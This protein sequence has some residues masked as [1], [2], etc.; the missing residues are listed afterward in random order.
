MK[1]EFWD[2]TLNGIDEKYTDSAAE[3]LTKE[4][5]IE[6]GRAR[7]IKPVKQ[8]RSGLAA[9]IGVCATAAAALAVVVGIKAFNAPKNP[10]APSD[11]ISM[12]LADYTADYTLYEKY[13]E[14]VWKNTDEQSEKPYLVI[15]HENVFGSLDGEV[16]FCEAGEECAMTYL[17][18]DARV[19]F[20]RDADGTLNRYDCADALST[21]NG[22]ATYEYADEAESGSSVG[23]VYYKLLCERREGLS[24]KLST[25]ELD[26]D[27][28]HWTRA[29]TDKAQIRV[30]SENNAEISLSAQFTNDEGGA[31]YLKLNL[32]G[33]GWDFDNVCE[34]DILNDKT[35]LESFG[36]SLNGEFDYG[37]YESVF[38]G[39]WENAD[40]GSEMELSYSKTD[41]PWENVSSVGYLDGFW[42][43]WGMSGGAGEFLYIS[44]EEPDVMYSAELNGYGTPI[45][46]YA[47][48]PYNIYYRKEIIPAESAVN[49]CTISGAQGSGEYNSRSL[50]GYKAVNDYLESVEGF[51]DVFEAAHADFT[52]ADGVTW[53]FD[54]IPCG[55]V[56][57]GYPNRNLTVF[58]LGTER[59]RIGVPFIVKG[60][61]DDSIF[62]TDEGLSE[63][64]ENGLQISQ[65]ELTFEK[66]QGE[67]V[68]ISARRIA[69]SIES[70]EE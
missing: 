65:F 24:E 62:D 7:E 42:V 67:W 38:M 44:E 17:E 31:R 14:G 30:Y 25:M 21:E 23:T 52:D 60:S 43:M 34:Y 9:A 37:I 56:L 47:N 68:F 18:D 22:A 28:Q 54:D 5:D 53:S 12:D 57:V 69:E 11:K 33:D 70:N 2:K 50:M 49:I 27:G 13:F 19:L 15:N 45:S 59:I 61:F 26:F 41:I 32:L 51:S 16:L 6:E 10:V 3:F 36:E 4:T 20:V 63:F 46:K 1:N 8:K 66:T 64:F 40:S 48:D 58:E 39:I 35:V 55:F 29:G